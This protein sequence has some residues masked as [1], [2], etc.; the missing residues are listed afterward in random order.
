MSDSAT[1]IVWLNVD[2]EAV[3]RKAI[4]FFCSCL[5]SD[6]AH[7]IYRTAIKKII[8]RTSDHLPM[9]QNG[10]FPLLQ[11]TRFAGT[12]E[13]LQAELVSFPLRHSTK[14]S[15]IPSPQEDEHYEWNAITQNP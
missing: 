8:S 12:D 2:G 7:Y 5:S 6:C 4:Q 14:R 3:G 15:L 1:K 11:L 9:F 13:G 10:H